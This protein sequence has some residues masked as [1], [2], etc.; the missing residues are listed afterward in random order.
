[1]GKERMRRVFDAYE[2]LRRDNVLPSTWEVIYAQA[3]APPPGQPLRGD[4]GEIA[5]V[6]V[7]SIP[8]RRR[9]DR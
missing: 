3:F 7:S 1:M 4:G 9:A 2:T 8:I 6:P 5:S